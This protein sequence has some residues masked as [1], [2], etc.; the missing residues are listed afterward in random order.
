MNDKDRNTKIMEVAVYIQTLQE[1]TYSNIKLENV[2]NETI[3]VIYAIYEGEPYNKKEHTF[4]K[5]TNINWIEQLEEHPGN[6]KLIGFLNIMYDVLLNE[7][8][9]NSTVTQRC[10]LII[11]YRILYYNHLLLNYYLKYNNRNPHPDMINYLKI[12]SPK[13]FSL[14]GFMLLSHRSLRYGFLV[15]EPESTDSTDT[16]VMSYLDYLNNE[17]IPYMPIECIEFLHKK[18]YEK[19]NTIYNPALIKCRND[20]DNIFNMIQAC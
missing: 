1:A 9:V 2:R 19:D 8:Y 18:V 16:K 15:A 17:I 10:Q 14:N 7:N 12:Q 3:N 20:L 5:N 13:L 6:F 11:H 4:N